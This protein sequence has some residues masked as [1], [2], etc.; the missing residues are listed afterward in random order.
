[1]CSLYSRGYKASLPIDRTPTVLQSE[2]MA[3][4]HGAINCLRE[5]R[6][7]VRVIFLTDSKAALAQLKAQCIKKKTVC[8]KAQE[9]LSQNNNRV[10]VTYIAA[11]RGNI[12]NVE[13]DEMAKNAADLTFVGAE[14]TFGISK[15][16]L[17]E[18]DRKIG[19][20]DVDYRWRNT[21]GLRQSKKL[22]A[23]STERAQEALKLIKS[24]LKL[25]TENFTGH[26]P[27][28]YHLHNIGRARSPLCRHC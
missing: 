19:K 12:G 16:K 26:G 25:I 18:L 2:L 5:G 23:W 28:Y 1:M 8:R 6:R 4:T 11:Y 24:E 27:V 17:K 9:R 21:P 10:T 22:I 7:N 20:N 14:P 13:A 15:E 3:I